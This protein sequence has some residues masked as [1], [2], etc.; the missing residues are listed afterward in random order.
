VESQ[1]LLYGIGH[2][3]IEDKDEYINEE[4]RKTEGGSN[5]PKLPCRNSV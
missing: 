4:C 2:Q 1:Q 5:H 3:E